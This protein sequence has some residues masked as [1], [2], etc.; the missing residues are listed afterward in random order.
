MPLYWATNIDV[1]VNDEGYSGTG[2][3]SWWFKLKVMLDKPGWRE[4]AYRDDSAATPDLP[5]E[6]WLRLLESGEVYIYEGSSRGRV[7]GVVR[8]LD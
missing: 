4:Y 8:D 1:Q 6:D 7:L 5:F 2:P 3:A